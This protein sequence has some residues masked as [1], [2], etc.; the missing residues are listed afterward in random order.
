MS[1]TIFV[2]LFT[3]IGGAFLFGSVSAQNRNP[4]QLV[5]KEINIAEIL[6]IPSG[7]EFQVVFIEA[8][9][10]FQKV[11]QL[12]KEAP[13]SKL[14]FVSLFESLGIGGPQNS[15]VSEVPFFSLIP[16]K[17]ERESIIYLKFRLQK[18]LPKRI[19]R[20]TL[21]IFGP[22]LEEL[23][24]TEGK[25]YEETVSKLMSS[26]S[27]W[28]SSYD[29]WKETTNS[30]SEAEEQYLKIKP[31]VGLG[32]PTSSGMYSGCY[33]WDVTEVV[34]TELGKDRMVTFLIRNENIEF[35]YGVNIFSSK[36]HRLWPKRVNKSPRL[37]LEF[38][39]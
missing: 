25:G 23:E 5:D 36:M 29:Q 10:S 27:L 30:S 3:I 17:D 28:F 9:S 8:D 6:S 4:K 22:S 18:L 7:N 11:S 12:R 32:S 15:W 21:V 14:F 20:A 13:A 39:D 26:V 16:K 1:K 2:F 35:G 38:V 33:Y 24:M 37:V 34:N 31:E 19:R